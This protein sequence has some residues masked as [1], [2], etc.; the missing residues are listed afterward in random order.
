[1]HRSETWSLNRENK[2]ALHQAEMRMLRWTC[3]VKLGDKLSC[4][5]LRQRLGIEDIG[6]VVQR[7]V[8]VML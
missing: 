7:N 1:M 3:G 4:I 8:V 2:L 6:K 5:E